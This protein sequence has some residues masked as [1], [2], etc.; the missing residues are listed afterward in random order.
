MVLLA[1]AGVAARGRRGRRRRALEPLRQ[2]DGPAAARRQRDRHD[3]PLAHRATCPRSAARADV[4]SP[5]SAATGWSRA[6]GS[7][8]ARPSSTS[9]S[10]APTTASTATSTSTRRSQVAGAITPVPGGVGP[11]TIACLLRNTLHGGRAAARGR[12]RREPAARRRVDRGRRRGRRCSSR[13]SCDWF[14]ST[15]RRGRRRRPLAGSGA[16]RLGQPRLAHAS[17]LALAR[18]RLRRLAGDRQRAPRR[19]VARS[20]AASC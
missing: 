6:T 13:S 19:P 14:A 1:E 12:C 18:D 3:L 17:L 8:P 5:P 16:Q 20:V 9:A 10:T 4:L 15:V 2:A 7:S 11:M